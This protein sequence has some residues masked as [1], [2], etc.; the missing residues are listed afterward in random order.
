MLF[1]CIKCGCK[2]T[3]GEYQFSMK[4]FKE[5]LCKRCQRIK[6]VEQHPILGSM[7]NK[8]LDDYGKNKRNTKD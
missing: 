2:L 6:R 4:W 1:K 5:K 3:R 7:I 8:E